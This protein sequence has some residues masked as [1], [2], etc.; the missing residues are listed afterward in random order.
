MRKLTE[1]ERDL[2]RTLSET[3]PEL[4]KIFAKSIEF[5]PEEEK[6]DLI[7]RHLEVLKSVL[8]KI[9]DQSEENVKKQIKR[10]RNIEEEVD[11]EM[12]DFDKMRASKAKKT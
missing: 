10:I 5:D 2:M 11:D 6:L 3:I 1:V 12:V 7:C 9:I 4:C 8:S